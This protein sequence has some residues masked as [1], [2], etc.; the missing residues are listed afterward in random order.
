[1]TVV[2]ITLNFVSGV[3]VTLST[4]IRSQKDGKIRA[5]IRQFQP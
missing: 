3:P 5:K 1:M 4:N 2:N